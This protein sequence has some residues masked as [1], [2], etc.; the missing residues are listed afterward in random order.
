MPDF[1]IT[2]FGAAQVKTPR[3]N[4]AAIQRALDAAG[5]QG[6][7]RVVVPAGT[8]AT[9]TIRLRSH[10]EL[11]LEQGA[12]LLA[13]TDE[14]DYNPLDEYPE[15]GGCAAEQWTHEHLII[16]NRLEDVS[17]TGPGTID[18]HAEA[19][20]DEPDILDWCGAWRTG[21][22]WS[23]DKRRLRPGQLIVFILCRDIAVT[24]LKVRQSTCWSLFLHGCENVIVRGYQAH[25]GQADANTDGIDIDSC[26]NV[27]V[28]D[29][30]IDTGDDAIAIR[31]NDT[32]L[33]SPRPC[34][35]VTITNCVLASS[36]AGVR[37]GVGCGAIRH[38]LLSN[39]LFTR[40]GTGVIVQSSYTR[41]RPKGVD[42]AHVSI[43]QSTFLDTG[44]PFSI[45]P[46]DPDAAASIRDIAFDA[47]R[48]EGFCPA[49]IR[50]S[51]PTRPQDIRLSDCT[52]VLSDNPDP[53][54]FHP[55]PRHL[56][57][58]GADDVALRHCRLLLD[59]SRTDGGV[60]FHDA[61][62]LQ[63]G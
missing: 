52:L 11:H 49:V 37:I 14:A 41:G 34:E 46:G 62:G 61:P 54:R 59:G 19:F 57:V 12:T 58:D 8:F 23:R 2:A 42:I 29:C 33:P 32:R 21:L 3:D 6:G 50:R 7:G 31:G 51:G 24:D 40:S 38:V 43:R 30:I 13:A 28:S 26:R 1:L 25:N 27:T 56:L 10:V 53:Q 5:A 36:S 44:I 15:N 17:I 22:R 60:D 20:Y 9:G 63:L 48:F 35:F 16:A 55:G 45:V 39:L 4:T 18:G 47:C